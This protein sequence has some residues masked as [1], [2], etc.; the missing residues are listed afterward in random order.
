[1]EDNTSASRLGNG[2]KY[3]TGVN[4]GLAT[5]VECERSCLGPAWR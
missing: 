3:S 1:M 5:V 2:G 4:L